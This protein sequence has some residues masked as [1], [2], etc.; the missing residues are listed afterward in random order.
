LILCQEDISHTQRQTLPARRASTA[1]LRR[2]KNDE[3]IQNAAS[4]AGQRECNGWNSRTTLWR[5][6]F[7]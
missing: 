3:K 4:G 2:S 5:N 1:K 7:E 6:D